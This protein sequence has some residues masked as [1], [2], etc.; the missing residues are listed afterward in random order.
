MLL[1]IKCQISIWLYCN[2]FHLRVGLGMD[3]LLINRNINTLNPNSDKNEICLYIISTCLN[4][5]VMRIRKVISKDEM[6]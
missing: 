1:E 6:S 5:Q 4:V 3:K 2:N